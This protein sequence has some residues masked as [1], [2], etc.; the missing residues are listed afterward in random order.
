MATPKKTMPKAKRIFLIANS[1]GSDE[2]NAARKY[3]RFGREPL[4]RHQKDTRRSAC[5]ISPS[6]RACPPWGS[7]GVLFSDK[8]LSRAART[9]R[10]LRRAWSG[11]RAGR[12]RQVFTRAIKPTRRLLTTAFFAVLLKIRWSVSTCWGAIPGG[13]ARGDKGKKAAV[14]E[15]II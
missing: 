4:L 3:D 10:T 8:G 14:M 9:R 15:I 13:P 1:L 2:Q 6:P 7:Q 11:Q 12:F 5:F